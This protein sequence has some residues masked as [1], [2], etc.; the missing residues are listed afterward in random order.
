MVDMSLGLATAPILY[1]TET[2]PE[3]KKI[4]KRRFKDKVRHRVVLD[5]GLMKTEERGVASTPLGETS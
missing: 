3:I 5:E 2:A 4:I 1:A